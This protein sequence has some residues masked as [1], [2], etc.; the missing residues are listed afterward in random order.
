MSMNQQT[1]NMR[2]ILVRTKPRQEV[3][4]HEN[5]ERQNFKTYLPKLQLRKRRRVKW[6]DVIEPLFPGYLFVQ[7]DPNQTSIAPIRS[8]QG[9]NGI[10]RFGNRLVPVPDEVIS[11]LKLNEQQDSGYHLSDIP[12]FEKGEDVQF[13]DGPFKGLTG[14]F[15]MDKE[16]DRVMILIK[17]LGRP[18]S[19]TVKLDD[20]VKNR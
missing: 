19:I 7:V 4:A 13:V 5:L 14:V 11:F 6:I 1:S 12:L 10:V 9:V 18:N 17:I 8:T 15:Q 2:W 20:V 16:Q 3:L